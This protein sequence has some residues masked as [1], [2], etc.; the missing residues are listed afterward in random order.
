MVSFGVIDRL[1]H[2]GVKME[3]DCNLTIDVSVEKLKW[4]DNNDKVLISLSCETKLIILTAQEARQLVQELNDKAAIA[5]M[6]NESIDS[7]TK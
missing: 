6:N 1:D 5:A 3:T 2:L 4:I 7:R